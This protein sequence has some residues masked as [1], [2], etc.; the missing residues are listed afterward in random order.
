[1]RPQ[2]E[3]CVTMSAIRLSCAP[4]LRSFAPAVVVRVTVPRY[5]PD[6]VPRL[7]PVVAS[8][9]SR[10]SRGTTPQR[11]LVGVEAFPALSYAMTLKQYSLPGVPVKDRL[12]AVTCDTVGVPNVPFQ[13]ADRRLTS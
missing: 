3:H 10:S 9:R 8:P 4:V 2:V 11:S 7:Q 13:G 12:V 1:M 6:D 5:A